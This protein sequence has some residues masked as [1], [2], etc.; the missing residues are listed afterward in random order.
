MALRKHASASGFA[1]REPKRLRPQGQKLGPAP[2][3]LV[4]EIQ[5]KGR[6]GEPGLNSEFGVRVKTPKCQFALATI[7]LSGFDF[8]FSN[9]FYSDPELPQGL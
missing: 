3:L 5:V 2:Q 7:F 1:W 9:S 6:E 8:R 4:R